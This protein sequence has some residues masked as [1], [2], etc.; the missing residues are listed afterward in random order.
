[1]LPG[2]TASLPRYNTLCMSHWGKN[3]FFF[4]FPEKGRFKPFLQR[5]STLVLISIWYNC[6][7]S[8]ATLFRPACASVYT[9]SQGWVNVTVRE[10]ALLWEKEIVHVE[11]LCGVHVYLTWSTPISKWYK[12]KTFLELLKIRSIQGPISTILKQPQLLNYPNNENKCSIISFHCHF[13][14]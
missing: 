1:M 8:L 6:L 9:S 13:L 12:I 5:I 4:F 3:S 2:G 11:L 10:A 14:N 7:F